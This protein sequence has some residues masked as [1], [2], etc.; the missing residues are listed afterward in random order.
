[1]EILKPYRAKID[2]IDD[3]IVDLLS[4]REEI[5]RE[6]GELKFR[7]NIAPILQDRVDE[8]RER[9]IAR[10]VQKGANPELI[11]E[12]YT[13]IIDYSCDLEQIIA[14]DLKNQQKAG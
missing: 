9:C 7:E 14:D 2:Q 8:V 10:A 4:A 13:R 1:M 11:K 5:I 3:Q 6:V 12:L